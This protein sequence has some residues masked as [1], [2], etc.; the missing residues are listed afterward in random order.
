MS[1]GASVKL[2]GKLVK[3][4]G[5]GQDYDF[6]VEDLEVLGTCDPAVSQDSINTLSVTEGCPLRCTHYKKRRI[7]MSIFEPTPTCVPELTKPQQF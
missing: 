6:R 1:L 5:A 3:S 7:R 2:I 4:A